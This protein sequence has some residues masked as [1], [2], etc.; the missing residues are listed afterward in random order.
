M[1]VLI[2][3]KNKINEALRVKMNHEELSC[4]TLENVCEV[5][6]LSVNNDFYVVKT[7][8]KTFE[9][10]S[11]IITETPK[12]DALEV[13]GTK[14]LNLTDCSVSDSLLKAKVHDK[15]VFLLDY[16]V[17]SP[18]HMTRKALELAKCMASKKK[19]VYIF[20]RFMRTA[21]R[22][23]EEQYR[24]ARNL[25]IT[26]VKYENISV[27]YSDDTQFTVK[28]CDGVFE[29]EIA[30]SFVVADGV[31]NAEKLNA[32]AS[33]LKINVRAD[34]FYLYPALTSR[35][36]IYMFNPM[37]DASDVVI[38][39]IKDLKLNCKEPESF[40][41][42]DARKCAFCYSCYRACPHGALVP[43]LENSAMKCIESVC[44]ACGTCVA[45][46]PGQAITLSGDTNKKENN[47]KIKILC[48]ENGARQAVAEIENELGDVILNLDIE[49]VPCGGNIGLDKITEALH[50]HQKVLVA[51]CKDDA[52]RHFVGGKRACKQVER[53]AEA[54]KTANLDSTTVKSIQVSCA[55][56]NVLKDCILD[57]AKM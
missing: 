56:P 23:I 6:G 47:K 28:A 41:E 42:I 7:A 11:I 2:L 30:T 10:Q 16:S 32:L 5:K 22:E 15:I 27:S 24:E 36:N 1:D 38:P 44:D 54:L 29:T 4:E 8:D 17:E 25:G 34:R 18:E 37:A 49:S 50:S 53:T 26:F 46:C 21:Q 39:S 33:V 45:I 13:D 57:F 9:A 31:K 12:Y 52:C 48:C 43:D 14:L 35:K 20:N 55:M 3:G 19:Q 40:A 51:V